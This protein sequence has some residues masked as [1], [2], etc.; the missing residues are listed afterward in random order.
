MAKDVGDRR[1]EFDYQAQNSD[2]V[3]IKGYWSVIRGGDD[4]K[5]RMLS[6]YV[7]PADAKPSPSATPS[8]E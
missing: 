6:P 1:M 7:T 8:N 5:I 3:Q 2:L 4:L